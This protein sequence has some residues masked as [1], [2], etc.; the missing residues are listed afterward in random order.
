MSNSIDLGDPIPGLGI[1]VSGTTGA[2][3][4]AAAVVLTLTLPDGTTVTPTV[5]NPATG[6]YSA[7]HTTTQ[8]GRYVARWVATGITGGAPREEHEQVFSVLPPGRVLVSLAE[9]KAHLN[10]PA[11]STQHDGEVEAFVEAITDAVET[12]LGRPLRPVTTTTAFTSVGRELLLNRVPCACTACA[13]FRYLTVASVTEDGR[14]LTSSDWQLDAEA[15]ILRRGQYGTWSWL[16]MRVRGVVVVYS[17][18][19]TVTPPWARLAILRGLENAWTRS[20]QRPHPS[21]G[22]GADAEFLP[23]S[24]YALPYPVQALIAPHRAAGF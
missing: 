24:S 2:A 13:P 12:H 16:T 21:Y 19:Y 17:A 1:L 9:A 20:Q 6:L 18:G 14:A 23:G 15:G 11:T 7:V 4:S 10:L 5:A 8:A 22:Q 3:A